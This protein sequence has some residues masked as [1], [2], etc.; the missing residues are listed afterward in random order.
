[1]G[2]SLRLQKEKGSTAGK[3]GPTE[4]AL[5]QIWG[6]TYKSTYSQEEDLYKAAAEYKRL[7]G[8]RFAV[9]APPV[10]LSGEKS[11]TCYSVEY[12]LL[13]SK[14]IDKLLAPAYTYNGRLPECKDKS[15]SATRVIDAKEVLDGTIMKKVGDIEGSSDGGADTTTAG[16]ESDYSKLKHVKQLP[17]V[18][19]DLTRGTTRGTYHIPGYQGFLPCNTNNP[20]CATVEAGLSERQNKEDV[21]ATYAVNIP[22]YS[23]HQPLNAINDR[24]PRQITRMTVSG[25]DFA[26]NAGFALG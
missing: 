16:G 6:S 17:T 11:V 4:E 13:G 26:R 18:K 5:S 21:R 8:P 3:K 15:S 12:G 25:R 20:R 9:A 14:P 24:G 19:H 1:M 2:A 22:G 7:R 10:C 23:G